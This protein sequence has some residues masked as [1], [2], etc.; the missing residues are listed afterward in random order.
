MALTAV[1]AHSQDPDSE[2]A[3]L[4]ILEQCQ[5]KLNGQ[6]P[7]IGILYA[8][9][10]FEFELILDRICTAFPEIQLIGGTTDAEISSELGF[11]QDSL[12][13][14]LLSADD[15]EM[16]IGIG[17]D[18]SQDI[19]AATHTAVQQAQ[20]KL[21]QPAQ[22][23]MTLADTLG[24]DSNVIVKGLQSVLGETFPILGG[25]TGDRLKF[26]KTW[27]FY[28][29]EVLTNSV[30]V[31]LF[32]GNIQFSHSISHG[33]TP[34]TEPAEITGANGTCLQSINGQPALEF[35]KHYLNGAEPSLE[36]PF[37]I[38]IED[39]EQFYLRC[40]MAGDPAKGEITSLAGFPATGKLQIAHA[41]RHNVIDAAGTAF[42]QALEHYPATQ[43]AVA[44][45]FSCCTRRLIMGTQTD[46]EYQTICHFD[47]DLPIF[48]FYSYGE[49]APLIPNQPAQLHH[50][51]LATLL[52]GSH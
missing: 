28:N 14:L 1:V 42:Q 7:Q 2:S 49:I 8:A 18:L 38:Q 19:I 35:Y 43:P 22:L 33:W 44:L 5:Q 25:M 15:V 46:K 29:R 52:I 45:V 9:I 24:M 16:Q 6:Q 36:Y 4:E 47:P 37:A 30:L 3:V 12:A 32:A 11:Q 31:L 23:C 21:H 13:L 41:N 34:L 50:E 17:R 10:D 51:V 20:T 26:E 48:G 27:Q 39:G 40:P